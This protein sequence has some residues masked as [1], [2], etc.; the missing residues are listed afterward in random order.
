MAD[1]QPGQTAE[2]YLLEHKVLRDEFMSEDQIAEADLMIDWFAESWKFK[3]DNGLFDKWQ[4]IDDY[5][6][7]KANE[8]IYADDIGSNTNII[9]PHVEGQVAL[10]WQDPV[11]AYVKAVD[12]SDTPY[13]AEA[14]AILDFCVKQNKVRSI[15][16]HMYR[17]LKKDGITICSVFWDKTALKGKGIPRI[18]NWSARSVYF[19][20]AITDTQDFQESR[21]VILATR[22]S[23]VWAHETFGEEKASAITAGYHPVEGQWE[24]GTTASWSDYEREN[25]SY[26]HLY[27]LTKRNSKKVRL[28]QMTS[29]GVVLDEKTLINNEY[30]VFF[31]EQ[32]HCEGHL[33]GM[34]S[35][36][37]LL[38]LQDKI[39]DLDDQ[40]TRNTRL[41][42][43]PQKVVTT[44]SGIIMD[45]WTNEQGLIIRANTLSDAYA[46]IQP[47]PVSSDVPLQR[48]QTMYEDRLTIGRWSDS[49]MGKS[50]TGVDTATEAAALQTTGM[51]IIDSD[52]RKVQ[53]MFSDMLVYSL[54]LSEEY[55]NTEMAFRITGKEKFLHV[56]PSKLKEIPLMSPASQKYIMKAVKKAQ[57]DYKQ[58]ELAAGRTAPV[59]A[60]PPDFTPPQYEFYKVDGKQIYREAVYDIDVDFG[61]DVPS[62][63]AFAL[64][65]VKEAYLTKAID[66]TEYR[67]KLHDLHILSY[68]GTDDEKTIVEGIKAREEAMLQKDQASATATIMNAA[69]NNGIS[70]QGIPPMMQGMPGGTP[71]PGNPGANMPNPMIPGMTGNNAVAN[72]ATQ[73][74][75]SIAGG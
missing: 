58:S 65:A 41:M 60:L 18:R 68:M 35:T 54:Q 51:A 33:Y 42:G 14:Q 48:R 10:S 49:M 67:Q 64:N 57:S 63:K 73:P 9:N 40:M 72:P 25:T 23:L 66:V 47:V 44:A 11:A 52:K 34:S 16:D 6:A 39:N 56:R 19:D 5:W 24:Y 30:P 12:P 20:P 22:K 8:P 46:L 31:V 3:D 37:L 53:N 70:P 59:G 55:W 32:A 1:Y 26:L 13:Q 61:A 27:I 17:R 4:L 29:D 62:N 43:N 74:N 28:I 2:A 69:A 7:G 45:E 15:R 50:Q 36:E 75:L 71:M 21:Y 38:P